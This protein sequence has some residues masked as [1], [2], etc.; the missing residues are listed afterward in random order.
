MKL[1]FFFSKKYIQGFGNI[2]KLKHFVL[3]CVLYLLSCT[4]ILPD[5][6]YGIWHDE[7]QTN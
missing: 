2:N 7:A 1:L 5:I 6:N 4:F 3:E